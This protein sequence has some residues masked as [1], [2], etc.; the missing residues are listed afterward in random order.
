MS[1][2]A[3]VR[4]LIDRWDVILHRIPSHKLWRAGVWGEYHGRRSSYP[5]ERCLCV[6]KCLG[7]EEAN[8]SRC[9]HFPPQV[10]QSAISSSITLEWTLHISKVS[11]P[12]FSP[13]QLH[14]TFS[15]CSRCI[16]RGVF[17]AC[18]AAYREGLVQ[19]RHVRSRGL[20]FPIFSS[21]GHADQ[22]NLHTR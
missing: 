8:A 7:V 1:A 19:R 5:G 14:S 15:T 20:G 10:V 6:G 17:T 4:I 13:Q 3:I 16:S 12:S 21:V 2:F 18:W 11:N 9:I 22:P